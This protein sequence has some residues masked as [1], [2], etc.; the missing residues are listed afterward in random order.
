[1]ELPKNHHSL[2][3]APEVKQICADFFKKTP[4]THFTYSRLYNNGKAMVLVSD[5]EYHAH[6]WKKNYNEEFFNHYNPGIYLARSLC[7]NAIRDAAEFQINFPMMQIYEKHG[8][9]EGI[10]LGASAN[11]S[12]IL[13]FY[14]NNIDIIES[15]LY[16]FKYRAESLIEESNKYLLLPAKKPIQLSQTN[17]NRPPTIKKPLRYIISTARGEHHITSREYDCLKLLS[18][19][20]TSKQIAQCLRVSHRTVEAHLNNIKQRLNLSYKDELIAVFMS[21]FHYQK[22]R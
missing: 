4:I 2:V 9:H 10:G 13:E 7:S 16:Y 8:Y 15:F 17:K 11:D 1:M 18:N 14:L 3:H 22:C 6:F 5:S 21:N 12:S 19:G 20:F